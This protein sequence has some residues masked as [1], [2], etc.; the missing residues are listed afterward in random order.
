M[1]LRCMPTVSLP[2]LSP[3]RPFQ[4]L[5]EA[6]LSLSAFSQAASFEMDGVTRGKV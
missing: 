2:N 1:T 4:G 6:A 5:P 3:P